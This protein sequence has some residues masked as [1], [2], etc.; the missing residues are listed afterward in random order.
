MRFARRVEWSLAEE[1][2]VRDELARLNSIKIKKRIWIDGK[3]VFHSLHRFIYFE[4]VSK[5][6]LLQFPY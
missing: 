1:T 2:R 4:V 3:R 6:V 5:H